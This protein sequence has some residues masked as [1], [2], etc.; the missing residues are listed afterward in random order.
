[1]TMVYVDSNP[2]YCIL[3]R[4]VLGGKQSHWMIILHE[5]EL[6][7]GKYN[8]KKSLIFTYLMYD[9]PCITKETE[10]IDSLPDEY[11]FLISM[12]DP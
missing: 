2:M 3:T 11:L 10:P 5:F 7:F 1:M 8:S 6:E 12:F 4:Q 9:L